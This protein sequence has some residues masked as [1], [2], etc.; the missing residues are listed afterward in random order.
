MMFAFLT[1]VSLPFYEEFFWVHPTLWLGRSKKNHFKNTGSL[2]VTWSSAPS[3]LEL[4]S[5]KRVIFRNMLY[6]PLWRAWPYSRNPED[7]TE[8]LSLEPFIKSTLHLFPL[9]TPPVPQ[10]HW[11]VWQLCCSPN[12]LQNPFLLRA[13][14]KACTQSLHTYTR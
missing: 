1:G 9:V 11:I 13:A 12:R 8:F 10:G 2:G 5:T 4:S 6:P 14:H 3:L 7:Y